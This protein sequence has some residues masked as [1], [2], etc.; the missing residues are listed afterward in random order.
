MG[1]VMA[2]V[3]L[4]TVGKELL[5]GRTVNTNA[6]WVGGRLAKAGTTLNRVTTVDDDLGEISTAFN[7]ALARRPDFLIVVGGLGPTPDDMTLKGI[8]VALGTRL[9]L[10][11]KAL[12]L[13]KDHYARR[14]LEKI[15]LTSARMKMAVLPVGS[16][17][18]KNEVGT[19]PGVRFELGKT[20]AI[21]LPGVPAEMRGMFRRSV[22]PEIINSVGRL[23]RKYLRFKLE[24][25][26]EST[27]APVIARELKKHPGVYIK[28]HPRGVREGIS[29]IELD[30]AVVGHRSK[31][32]DAEAIA[33]G[34]E[35]SAS[36]KAMGGTVISGTEDARG[37]EA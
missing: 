8:A 13:V 7:E 30:I 11:R 28:S 35:M 15:E 5:I 23:H 20:I 14:G 27:L 26:L 3:E 33:I 6:T 22:E 21:A 1:V 31:E 29:R 17:P 18:V 19:A 2:K 24:G 4:L 16:E 25:V 36:A 9:R 34:S 32:V 12:K 10:N 37:R